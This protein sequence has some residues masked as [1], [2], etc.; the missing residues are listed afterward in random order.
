MFNSVAVKKQVTYYH[1]N[2]NIFKAF[3][4]YTALLLPQEVAPVLRV[5]QYRSINF[6][7]GIFSCTTSLKNKG[8]LAQNLKGSFDDHIFTYINVKILRVL[9]FKIFQGT[10]IVPLQSSF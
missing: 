7:L 1:K 3:L 9:F 8:T 6:L 5:K 2:E 4:I 10:D